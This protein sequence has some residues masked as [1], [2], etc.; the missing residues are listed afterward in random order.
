MTVR[1]RITVAAAQ[2]WVRAGDTRANARRHADMVRRAA[3]DLVVFPELSITGYHLDAPV[4]DPSGPDIAVVERACADARTVA[5]IGA[6]VAEAGVEFI[7]MIAVGLGRPTVVYRKA[8]PGADERE[9]FAA[10][11]GAGTV[12]IAGWRVGL[13]ICRDTGILE[14]VDATARQDIDLYACGVVHHSAERFEQNRRA[15]VIRATCR[16]PVVMASCAGPT[17]EGYD[18]TAGCSGIWPTSGEP[19]VISDAAPGRFARTTLHHTRG[20]VAAADG[21]AHTEGSPRRRW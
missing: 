7:A 12:D 14:H 5:L 4:V 11:P 15:R 19:P 16:A 13:A 3:A 6:P 1:E 10:G 17:G 8:H 18:S 21:R 9:R 2:P 20:T